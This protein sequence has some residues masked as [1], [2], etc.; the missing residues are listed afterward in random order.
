MR[1]MPRG[2]SSDVKSPARI[3]WAATTNST[4]VCQCESSTTTVSYS[5]TSNTS[6]RSRSSPGTRLI[7]LPSFS[8]SRSAY[9][10]MIV[11]TW[12]KSPAPATSPITPPLSCVDGVLDVAVEVEAPGAALAADAGQPGAA[13]R[14]G[15]VAD[16]ET[17]DPHG[18][19]DQPRRHPLG[20]GLVAGEHG[21]RQPVGRAVGQCDGFGF[22]GEGLQREHRAEHLLGEDLRAG[23]G[24]AE[25][26]RLV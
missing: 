23:R 19:G 22:A 12:A 3:A 15:Q 8:S 24:A 9:G 16:E 14:R 20:P 21:R 26:G 4:V 11:G 17:V 13:E 2:S 6:A 10:S 1:D 25:Q 5:S 7:S 18:A